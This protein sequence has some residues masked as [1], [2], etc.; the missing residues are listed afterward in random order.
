[1]ELWDLYD[2]ERRPLGRT[3]RR[4]DEMHPGEY[5]VVVE[6]W[7]VNSKKEILVTLRAATKEV[8]P[9]RWENT[10]GSV[11]AGE[12]SMEGAVRELHEETGIVASER[13]LIPLGTHQDDSAFID[14]YLLHRD[15]P[16]SGLTM[17]EG[18]TTAAK[19]ITPEQLG[20]MAGNGSFVAPIAQCFTLFKDKIMS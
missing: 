19:W 4:G 1:M 3:H 20:E 17:Q 6:I 9:N 14:L 5:H 7:V 16:I 12:T 2:S 8:F 15:I 13:E 18:E 11:L 10:G